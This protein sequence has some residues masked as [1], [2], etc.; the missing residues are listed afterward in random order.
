MQLLRKSYKNNLKNQ[1][2][3]LKRCDKSM[4]YRFNSTNANQPIASTIKKWSKPIKY[5][6]IVFISAT[7]GFVTGHWLLSD[8]ETDEDDKNNEKLRLDKFIGTKL[9]KFINYYQI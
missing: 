9:V 1:N 7:T 5:S 8:D 3:N 6:L 2:F 4:N